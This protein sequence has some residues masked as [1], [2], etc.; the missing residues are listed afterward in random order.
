MKNS[1]FALTVWF[2]MTLSA[3]GGAAEAGEVDTFESTR[4]AVEREQDMEGEPGDA[5]LLGVPMDLARFQA[6]AVQSDQAGRCVG[7]ISYDQSQQELAYALSMDLIT[8]EVYY[9]G[10]ANGYYPVVNRYN[11]ISAVCMQRATP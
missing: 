6:L 10:L 2:G 5:R 11:I 7:A 3:L 8:L 1:G 9:W 4:Q